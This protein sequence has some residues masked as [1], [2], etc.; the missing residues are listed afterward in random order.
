MIM[1]R[2]DLVDWWQQKL[3]CSGFK[4]MEEREKKETVPIDNCFKGE[5]ERNEVV[6]GGEGVRK[7]LFQDE[8]IAVC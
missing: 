5:E 7:G 3:A 2:I 6:T 4:R 8:E 1:I